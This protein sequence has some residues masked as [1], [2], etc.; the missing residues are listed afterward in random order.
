MDTDDGTM[1]D[2]I[3][4]LRTPSYGKRMYLIIENET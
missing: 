3:I 2:E 4:Y 1:I